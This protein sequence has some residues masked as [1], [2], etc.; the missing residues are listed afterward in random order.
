[1]LEDG[2][3]A[4]HAAVHEL[5]EG[6]GCVRVVSETTDCA[7]VVEATGSM[8]RDEVH[9][10]PDFFFGR[11]LANAPYYG[12]CVM[13]ALRALRDTQGAAMRERAQVRRRPVICAPL[14]DLIER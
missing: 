11:Q 14:P 10:S 8:V 4:I 12:V 6:V 9:M 3:D 13:L 5:D 7:T 2:E 1:M